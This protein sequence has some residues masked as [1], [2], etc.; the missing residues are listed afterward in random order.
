MDNNVLSG[1]DAIDGPTTGWAHGGSIMEENLALGLE[2]LKNVAI[3]TNK[4]FADLLAIPRSVAITTVKPSGTV[5]QLVDSSSGIHARHSPY[6]IRTVRADYKDPLAQFMKEKGVPCEPDVT[7]PNNLVYSFPCASPSGSI[8]RNQRSALDV[9][10]HYLVYKRH[11]CEHNPSITVSVKEH[12]WMDVGAWVFRNMSNIGGVSFLP[13]SDHVYQQAPYQETDEA[14]YSK[15]EAS[16]PKLDWDEF[17]AY[18]LEDTT[19]GM[20][21]LAC[22]SGVCEVT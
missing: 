18:E 8:T 21:D 11:W 12:E 3:E 15:L 17:A 13:D 4:E 9:L 2:K 20:Q 14:T 22:V 5:S 19:T 1:G 16:M 6:Y 7:N 10:E